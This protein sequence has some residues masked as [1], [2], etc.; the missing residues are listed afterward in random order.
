VG[1]HLGATIE[2]NGIGSLRG[3]VGTPDQ[4][5][6]LARAYEEVGVDQIIFVAQAGQNRHEHIC[7]AME[8]FATEVMPEFQDRDM[9][10]VKEKEER[11][12]PAIDA[13]LA[14]RQPPRPADPAYSLPA[15]PQP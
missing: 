14:R 3:A 12:A 1:D 13:A 7:E 6:D 11:L 5:R 4:V 8:L 15:L 2:R 10:H 9:Q